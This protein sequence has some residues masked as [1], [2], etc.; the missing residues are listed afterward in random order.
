MC[1]AA[2][3]SLKADGSVL[4]F[5]A[6][7]RCCE[8]IALKVSDCLMTSETGC[9]D[10]AFLRLALVRS[11]SQ[12]TKHQA[13]RA[14]CHQF[15]A[16]LFQDYEPSEKLWPHSSSLFCV[17]LQQLLKEVVNDPQLPANGAGG[18]SADTGPNAS[19]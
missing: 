4:G 7:L 10:V 14:L 18:G 9:K 3:G 8:I 19:G 13:R 16:E 5:Y 17:R 6:L 11:R 15:Y 2:S 12:D 1:L